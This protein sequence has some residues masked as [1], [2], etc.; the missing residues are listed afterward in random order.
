M[1][2]GKPWS[3]A[4]SHFYRGDKPDGCDDLPHLES[5]G[6][7]SEPFVGDGGVL[8][9]ARLRTFIAM[10]LG[11]STGDVSTLVLGGHGDLMV[12]LPTT[13]R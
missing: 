13:V 8:D 10:E 9:S 3:A 4:P 6:F 1:P 11:V 7:A 5:D 12:P 2:Q